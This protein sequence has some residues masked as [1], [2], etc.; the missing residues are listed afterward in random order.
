MYGQQ[1]IRGPKRLLKFT[2]IQKK[3]RLSVF[4]DQREFAS[5]PD[6]RAPSGKLVGKR[7]CKRFLWARGH[8]LRTNNLNSSSSND[9]QLYVRTI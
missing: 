1:P 3:G 9:E 2:K 6:L 8:A 5:L 4:S 7:E